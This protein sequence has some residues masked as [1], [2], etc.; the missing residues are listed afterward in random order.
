MISMPAMVPCV[1]PLPESPVAIYTFSLSRGI[2]ADEGE[3]VDR[4]HHLPR[5]AVATLRPRKSLAR[6]RLS[7]V[8]ALIGVV[9]LAGL[10]VLAAD[11]EDVVSVAAIPETECG[12]SG[13]GPAYPRAGLAA[14]CRFGTRA[15]TTYVR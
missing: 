1:M 14:R 7:R 12:R 8:E 15:P 6:P 10:V 11:D 9:R 4:L 13:T 5:P 3:A 2:A